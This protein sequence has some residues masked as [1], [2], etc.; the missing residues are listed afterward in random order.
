MSSEPTDNDE[1]DFT[2]EELDK[3]AE[4]IKPYMTT[5][6]LSEED[7]LELLDE[8]ESRETHYRKGDKRELLNA[9]GMC[10]HLKRSAIPQWVAQGVNE[11]LDKWFQL[12]V[13]TLDEAFDVVKPKGFHID[14]QKKEMR[15]RLKV[16]KRVNELIIEEGESIGAGLFEKV[17]KDFAI[18]GST[19][20]DYYYHH[21]NRFKNLFNPIPDKI[22]KKK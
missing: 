22:S 9:L 5:D 15:I 17:G 16:F 3:L 12:D 19:A 14:K 8:I 7:E 1:L 11:A 2:D 4:A 6:E 21:K 18:G 20:R 13:K 10:C